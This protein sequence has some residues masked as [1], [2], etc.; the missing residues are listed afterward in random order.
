VPRNTPGLGLIVTRE[1]D[2]PFPRCCIIGTG[3]FH[4]DPMV[5]LP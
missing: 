2:I 4:K 3:I 5:P 1:G